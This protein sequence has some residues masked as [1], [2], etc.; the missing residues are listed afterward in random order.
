MKQHQTLN[1]HLPESITLI[2]HLLERRMNPK[3]V[4]SNSQPSFPQSPKSSTTENPKL[5]LAQ[6]GKTPSKQSQNLTLVLKTMKGVKNLH[7]FDNQRQRHGQSR[8]KI[9]IMLKTT[10]NPKTR[11]C[12]KT[13][14]PSKTNSS[15]KL[16]S[17]LLK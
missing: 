5:K 6:L 17:I 1:K 7:F 13:P 16:S 12:E 9:K 14:S 10:P 2:Y 11:P 8:P 3:E 4:S 15:S